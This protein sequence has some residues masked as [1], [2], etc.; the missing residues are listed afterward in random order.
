MTYTKASINA[1]GECV[2]VEMTADEEALYDETMQ[3]MSAF[4]IVTEQPQDA[5]ADSLGSDTTIAIIEG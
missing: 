1:K 4:L 2:V 3:A 5:D